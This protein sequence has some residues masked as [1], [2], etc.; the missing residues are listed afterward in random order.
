MNDDMKM[1]KRTRHAIY[2]KAYSVPGT[3]VTTHVINVL[4]HIAL[5][6]FDV[7]LCVSYITTN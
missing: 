5:F 3:V 6:Q 7:I 1:M 2:M 4:Y